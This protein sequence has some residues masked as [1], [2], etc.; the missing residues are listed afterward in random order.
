MG[1]ADRLQRLAKPDGSRSFAP[2]GGEVLNR[3]S[4]ARPDYRKVG[5]CTPWTLREV[6][7][8]LFMEGY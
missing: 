7:A 1:V 2:E 4:I 8:A 3:Q 5:D 6:E